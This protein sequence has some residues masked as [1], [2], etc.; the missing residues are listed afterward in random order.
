VT[1]AD[2]EIFSGLEPTDL[3]HLIHSL[4]VLRARM[5]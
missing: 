3:D 2:E 5:G 1:A 4:D